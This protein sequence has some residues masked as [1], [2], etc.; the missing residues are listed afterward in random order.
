[1]VSVDALTVAR[2]ALMEIGA[3]PDRVWGDG[4]GERATHSNTT[5]A[6]L[7]HAGPFCSRTWQPGV[8]TP[9]FVVASAPLLGV[10]PIVAP[11]CVTCCVV[12]PA[13]GQHER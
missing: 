4:C 7:R 10:W 13:D 1:M 6:T 5:P 12:S 2:A 8:P 11:R 3:D 9:R